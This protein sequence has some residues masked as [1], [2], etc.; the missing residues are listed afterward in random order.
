L[1]LIDKNYNAYR[2]DRSISYDNIHNCGIK[3]NKLLN[4]ELADKNDVE[5]YGNVYKKRI[6]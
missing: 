1:D 5:G 2:L 4:I 6:I 3:I